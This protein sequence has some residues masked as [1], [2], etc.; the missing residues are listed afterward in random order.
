M[1][2]QLVAPHSVASKAMNSTSLRS[3]N[4]LSARG[5]TRSAKHVANL[6]I[7]GSCLDRNHLLNPFC[8]LEQQ[9]THPNMRF[10]CP[11]DGGEEHEEEHEKSSLERPLQPQLTEAVHHVEGEPRHAVA[12][13]VLGQPPPFTHPP[14]RKHTP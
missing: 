9:L 4:A 2:V 5:S 1:S 3:C 14:H 12:E 13:L 10:P 6:F 7:D 11:Y 8:Q